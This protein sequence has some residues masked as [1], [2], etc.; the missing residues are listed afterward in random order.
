MPAAPL[1]PVLFICV[2]L[3]HLWFLFFAYSLR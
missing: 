1:F 3:C 2:H